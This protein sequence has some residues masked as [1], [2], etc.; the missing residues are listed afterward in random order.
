MGIIKWVIVVV[1]SFVGGGIAGLVPSTLVSLVLG[2]SPLVVVAYLV[3]WIV[4]GIFIWMGL[5]KLMK[6]QHSITEDGGTSK[7]SCALVD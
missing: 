4:G 3:G 2:S 7:R 1:G 6:L 5:F